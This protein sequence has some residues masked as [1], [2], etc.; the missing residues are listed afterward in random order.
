MPDDNEFNCYKQINKILFG[1]FRCDYG[2]FL[3]M[4]IIV[5][6]V[7][8]AL[9]IFLH[10][11]NQYSSVIINVLKQYIYIQCIYISP[12]ICIGNLRRT[13]S[14]ELTLPLTWG[15]KTLKELHVIS[16]HL[17]HL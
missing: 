15:M 13:I 6:T 12:N 17:E 1:G 10:D 4:I 7:I 8:I 9:Q 14:Y 11:C 5:F 16:I 3:I 2:H